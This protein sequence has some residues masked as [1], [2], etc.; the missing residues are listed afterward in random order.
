LLKP[1]HQEDTTM[2]EKQE[3]QTK[4]QQGGQEVQRATPM[5]SLA[6]FEDME[7]MFDDLFEGFFPRGMMRPMLQRSLGRLPTGFDG[8]FPRVDVIDRDDEILIRAEVPGVDK[9]DLDVSM[10]DDTVTIKGQTR[11][12]EK[13]ERGDYYRCEIAQGTFARTV[14][15]PAAVDS[16]KCKAQFKDGI[17]QLSMPKS[18]KAKRRSIKVE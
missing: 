16:E 4:Q 13:E 1:H 3:M 18:A 2:A 7:R 5:R 12:E 17:L 9:K 10:T 14:T 11:L 15:L 6:T 8:R